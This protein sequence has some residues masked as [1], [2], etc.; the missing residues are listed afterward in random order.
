MEWRAISGHWT[1]ET[2]IKNT[3]AGPETSI[4]YQSSRS[5]TNNEWYILN[6]PH[7]RIKK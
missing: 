6:K 1:G 4:K 7:D 5:L 3:E 2:S